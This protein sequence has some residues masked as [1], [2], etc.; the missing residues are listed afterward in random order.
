MQTLTVS[1]NTIVGV[2]HKSAYPA[3]VFFP[4]GNSTSK[5][6]LRVSNQL[7]VFDYSK[8]C[9]HTITFPTLTIPLIALGL[10]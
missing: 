2:K 9:I 5:Y 10:E 6:T 7:K 4:F 1:G 3:T 8:N